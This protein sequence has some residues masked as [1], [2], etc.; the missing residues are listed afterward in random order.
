MTSGQAFVTMDRISGRNEPAFLR[1]PEIAGLVVQ[2]LDDGAFRFQRYHLH[3]FVVMP[4]HAHLL[5]T[6]LVVSS[7]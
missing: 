3:S 7:A 1:Q 5:V 4:N 6:P 2:A